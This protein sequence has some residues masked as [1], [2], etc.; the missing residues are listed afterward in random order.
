MKADDAR[1]ITPETREKLRAISLRLREKNLSNRDIAD[2]LGVHEV[3]S[4][5]WWREYHQERMTGFREKPRGRRYATHRTLTFAQES[6]LWKLM[7]TFTPDELN[8]PFA[9]WTRKAVQALVHWRCQ[10]TMPLRTVG[11]YLKR[12]GC[13]PQKPMKRAYEQ[14]PLKVE[15]WLHDEYP[16]IV[17]R[18]HQEHGEIHWGDETGIQNTC[19]HVRGYAPCGETPVVEQ[20]GR[21]R[22]RL[23]MISTVTN[24]GK[25][26]FMLYEKT[27]T[28]VLLLTFLRRLLK[29]APS[30]VFLILDNLNVHRSQAVQDWLSLHRQ[31]IEVFYLPA[32][33]PE[34]NPDEYLNCDLKGGIQMKP[35]A[36]TV[37]ELKKKV[38]SHMKMLQ[39]L[40]Q[41]VKRYFHDPMIA[42]AAC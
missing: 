33:A 23:N 7:T 34:R 24:Q 3:T 36:H 14:N 19:H 4:S 10:V 11:E 27:M 37:G 21:Q 28:A 41:R 32:Y 1:K 15:Q 25:L 38:I 20:P 29:D 8:I 2:I 16:Q 35:A 40:P 22:I 13:P 5:R 42:Y 31:Q 30:K 12:W 17:Q 39:H 26:R 9:L 6:D 18:T